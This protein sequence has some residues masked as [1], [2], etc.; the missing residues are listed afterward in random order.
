MLEKVITDNSMGTLIIR[1][2]GER[3]ALI[4]KKAAGSNL[5][6]NH[7]VGYTI[8]ILN[9]REMAELISFVSSKEVEDA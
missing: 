8:I 3:F 6:F 9:P 1:W 4:D 5:G 7:A 2:D